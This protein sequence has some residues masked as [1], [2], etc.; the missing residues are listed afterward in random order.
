MWCLLKL[1]ALSELL[2]FVIDTSEFINHVLSFAFQY[3]YYQFHLGH[4]QLS[5]N[6]YC[7]QKLTKN[8]CIYMLRKQVMNN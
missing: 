8:T 7:V 4:N 3:Q 1:Y 2:S 5:H 6:E